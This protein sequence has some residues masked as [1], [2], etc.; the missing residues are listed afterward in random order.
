[1]KEIFES[2]LQRILTDNV[3]AEAVIAAEQT[4]WSQAIWD[5]LE[6]SG[7]TLAVSPEAVGGAGASW[8][9]MS[10]VIQLCGQY[11][12]PVPLPEAILSNWLLGAC[13]LEPL[14]GPLSFS[15]DNDLVFD[16][17]QL[18]GVVK[19]I[20]WGRHVS[21]VVVI[22]GRDESQN[23]VVLD[24]SQATDTRCESNTAG[25]PR[26]DLVFKNSV[27][28]SSVS[29]TESLSSD[30]L[31]VGGAMIR[32]AQTA[33]A[34]SAAID[35]AS[36]YASEREQFG[37]PIAKFQAIQHQL[38]VLAEHT[39]AAR[40]ATLAAFTESQSS[41]APLQIM[42]AKICCA[43][44]AGIGAAIAHSV[45]GA[46]GFTHEYPLHIF[47]RR[48]W[49]WRSEFGSATYWS[50][51]LGRKICAAGTDQFWPTITRGYL[52]A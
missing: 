38:A 5:V 36:N 1:M 35:M 34:L 50:E 42:S 9:D 27:P 18:S 52:V 37:K 16:G 2:T 6:E 10:G 4:G 39:L 25:E 31:L 7:F 43:E 40:V 21:H 30:V 44:A 12:L 13:G 17:T 3:P 26:D 28:V 8:E 32:S 51:A 33:G 41:F 24:T 45:H 19:Q 22:V 15:I 46:I 11:A 47:T 20:P 48:L 14:S 49:A 23:V 29:L